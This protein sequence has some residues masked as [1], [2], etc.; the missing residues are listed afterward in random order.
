MYLRIILLI[1]LPIFGFSQAP[2]K[3]NFQSI[4]R[5]TNGEV[6]A[7]KAV[8]LRI[9]ILSGSITGNTVYSETHDKTTDA[10]GLISLQIGNGTVING[11]FSTILWGN[12]AYFIK[13]EADFNGGSN[14]VLLGTQELMSVPYALYASKTDTSVLN[15]TNRF[16]SK[17]NISDTA[18]ML[19][20]YRNELNNKVNTSDTFFMLSNYWTG[21]NNKV[22]ISDTSTMLNPYLRKV[23]AITSG[24]V[25]TDPVFN[26]SVAKG[27]SG[28]DTAYWNR[29]LNPSD[30]AR[31]L[32]NY[33]NG[34]NNKVN[35]SDTSTMLNPYLRKT[36]DVI[37]DLQNQ[38]KILQNLAKVTDVDGNSYKTVKIGNQIWMAENLRTSKYQNG[39]SINTNL[40]DQSWSTATSG[41]FAI[42]ENNPTFD[43]SYGKLYNWYAVSDNRGICPTGWHVPSQ[44][45]FITLREYLGGA[46]VA[47]GKLK[48]TGTTFWLNPNINATNESGFSAVGGGTRN[49]GGSYTVLNQIGF[50]WSSTENLE[51]DVVN[52]GGG[53]GLSVVSFK[54][55]GYSVRCLK[56]AEGDLNQSLNLKLNISDTSTM[57]N[58]YL[59]KVDA[60]V[61]V[62]TDPVFNTS[63][64]KGISGIDT[65]YWNRKLNTAD[66]SNMLGNYRTGLNSKVN[67]SDTSTMLNPYL[68]KSDSIIADLQNQD[69]LL[70][71]FSNVIDIDGNSYKTLKI[72][73]QIW[74]AENLKTT[75]Y[76]NG[77]AIPTALTDVAW[78]NT[79]SGAYAIYNNDIA[80]DAIYGKLYNWYAVNDSRGLCPTGWHVPTHD[81]WTVLIDQLGGLSVAGGKMKIIGTTYWNSPNIG[82][83]NESGF[84]G[85]PSGDRDYLAGQFGGITH[86]GYFWSS[87]DA[88]QTIA[89]RTVLFN[90]SEFAQ[91]GG[92]P[93]RD[94]FSIRCLKDSE[95][96]VKQS[97][98][99]KVNISDTSTMLN[100]YLRKVD[101][102]VNV[103]TD[104]V[105]NSS[106]AKGISG[107]DTAYWNRKT[108]NIPGSI[109]YWNGTTWVNLAPGLPGQVISM[110]STGIPSWSGAAFPTLTTSAI[111][112]ITS[113]S[114]NAGGNISS[115]G[116][117]AVSARGLVYGT[118]SN[119][120]L[121]N[122][123]LSIGS[124]TGGYAG[125]ISG[126]TPN[127]TY[128][129]RA[130]AT[131]S[132]GTGYGDQVSFTTFPP[133]ISTITTLAV[134]SVTSSSVI[135]GGNVITD[136]GT[137]VTD[138]GVVY[139][140]LPNPT[141]ANSVLSIG[142]GSGLFSG[143]ITG[144]PASTTFYLRAF[145][146]NIAGTAYGDQIT[147]STFPASDPLTDISGNT[148]Q[149][150]QIGNQTWM[151]ENLRVTKY[152][153]GDI[154]PNVLIDRQNSL[155]G[156]WSYYLDDS[157]YDS[158]FGK[159]YNW[160]AAT[161]AR[162]ICPNGWHLP[163]PD[164]WQTLRN[165]LGHRPGTQLKEN[166][167]TF[168]DQRHQDT[169]TNSSG[170]SA[171]GAGIFYSYIS[172]EI[173]ESSR[174]WSNMSYENDNAFVRILF[175]DQSE[176]SSS[177]LGKG[178]QISIRCLKDN[179]FNLTTQDI[180]D[181]Q[182]SS[183]AFNVLVY[184]AGGTI[185]EIVEKG[186][187]YSTAANPNI[188]SAKSTT[189]AGMGILKVS[190][191][192]L[193]A[194]TTYYAR[195]FAKS[196]ALI[197]YGEEKVI[198]TPISNAQVV[199]DVE[200]NTYPIILLGTQTWMKENLRTSKYR[201]GDLIQ[202]TLIERQNVISGSQSS[203]LDDLY[204]NPIFGKLYN[205]YAATDVR[206]VCPI[207]WHIPSADEWQVLR[208]FLGDRPG[209]QLKENN[210]TYWDQ[211][212]QDTPT[213]S[214]G[215]SARGSG[216]FYSYISR[217]IRESSRFWSNIS[218]DNDNALVRTLFVDQS[219]FS[220]STLVK[221]NQISIRC[222]KD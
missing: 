215:F 73:Q 32:S 197:L 217:E 11:A 69:K 74:M 141:L 182:E 106:I 113:T 68:R 36:D 63:I 71:S 216:I 7:N 115:D 147:F 126:L 161:D 18:T 44:A 91:F 135:V 134:S 47:G 78:A 144:I 149:T 86:L 146:T 179:G 76:R 24:S 87:T 131:N 2:Q 12:A 57:L 171:R 166:N 137:A 48:L 95:I 30:T 102:I 222:L 8:S 52:N 60:M 193:I 118:T 201:N 14:Y 61:N 119:P 28:I 19:T 29:K 178:N 207:G 23:D 173:R 98:N 104:P 4:L 122:T 192:N 172:R 80:N 43:T 139:G 196:S 114:A 40:D 116:G 202:N 79:T 20:N 154:I 34:L 220:S 127:S 108:G 121:S 64:A 38:N 53:T 37:V 39:N 132:A 165:H 42:Y 9:S 35:N 206:G 67:I 58:P 84:G 175:A 168:W 16:N 190:L 184:S 70:Q 59:R 100:P 41:A 183:V 123:V 97:L 92:D 51:F 50:F 167:A 158:N 211:R 187:V 191:T 130:Y 112:S 26:V 200:G 204:Y 210:V 99:Q 176:F 45:E 72:G 152:R 160:Y 145:A 199:A 13:L 214:S 77:E 88:D 94:G 208:N 195:S 157:Y 181:L 198:T 109:Q 5:N 189:G 124:G 15:L 205:W 17:V 128:Y 6:V 194:G 162:G 31:M 140:T 107:I 21:L 65:A 185:P 55:T 148:Y 169:P 27:I 177:T 22:N 212:W 138:R 101:A 159:L 75:K 3:I 155:E 103:E 221:G 219:E 151:K 90:G 142:S 133:T 49:S 89:L 111:S 33:R 163:S 105:F 150:I 110:S 125:T 82:A 1:L 129:V 218:Y 117:A 66:T 188:L 93:K 213:N 156:A 136:G 96:D 83:T 56:N 85:L 54:T 120:T 10:S 153:N 81:E 174:F 164:E 209:T 62:E 186:I 143:S 180:L 46:S 170:F 203:Y 25:E